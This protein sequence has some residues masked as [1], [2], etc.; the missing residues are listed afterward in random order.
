MFFRMCFFSFGFPRLW[1]FVLFWVCGFLRGHFFVKCSMRV[2]WVFGGFSTVSCLV[3]FH[4]VSWCHFKI[5]SLNPKEFSY[6]LFNPSI[7]HGAS[8]VSI[9]N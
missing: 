9:G 2:S 5:I 1:A 4:D 8:Y 7:L 6:W 3:L